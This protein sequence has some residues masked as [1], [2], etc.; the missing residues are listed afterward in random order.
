MSGVKGRSGGARANSGG[1]RAGAGRP[2]K[3]KKPPAITNERDPLQFLLGVMSG[4]IEANGTQLRAAI[5]AAQYTS[6]KRDRL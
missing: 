3:P 2:P 5:A 6:V 1:V 4:A